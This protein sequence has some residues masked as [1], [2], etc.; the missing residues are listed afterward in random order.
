MKRAFILALAM[1]PLLAIGASGGEQKK[2]PGFWIKSEF[3]A[4]DPE[5][6]TTVEGLFCPYDADMPR[7]LYTTLITEDL[8]PPSE[9]HPVKLSLRLSQGQ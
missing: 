4:T 7:R 2:H 3:L 5:C 9:R 8:P 1:V 6:F